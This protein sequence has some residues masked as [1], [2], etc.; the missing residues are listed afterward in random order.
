VTCTCG[1]YQA[2]GWKVTDA[3]YITLVLVVRIK[4]KEKRREK[5]QRKGVEYE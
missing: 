3:R 5:I 2:Q 4:W 1:N